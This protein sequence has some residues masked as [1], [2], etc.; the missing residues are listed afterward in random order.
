MS[1]EAVNVD[2]PSFN[3]ERVSD[4][5]QMGSRVL[6]LRAKQARSKVSAKAT[7]DIM[8]SLVDSAV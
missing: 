2:G 1:K 4:D 3:F 5:T 8:K 6:I 7:I